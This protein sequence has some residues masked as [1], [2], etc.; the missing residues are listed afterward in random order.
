M[1]LLNVSNIETYYRSINAIK[2]VSLQVEEGKMVAILGANGAGK[3]TILVSISGIVE[4]QPEKGTIDFLGK[5]IVGLDPDK[6]VKMGISQVPQGRQVFDDLDV[7]ENLRLGA[8]SRKDRGQYREDLEEIY[9]LFPVLKHRAKQRAETLSGGEQQMLAI[10]RAMMA[11][12]RLLMLDEPSLGLSPIV[13][14]TIFGSIVQVNEKGTAVLLVEQNAKMAL[15]VAHEGYVLE[16]GR[17]VLFGTS[18]EL[19][20]NLSRC[21]RGNFH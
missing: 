15:K 19:L 4:N 3:T 18:E 12:P 7:E 5:Q 14:K 1:A 21:C 9:D 16:N 20:Q 11:K 13:V 8:Y 17:I 2:G 10:G 6:I